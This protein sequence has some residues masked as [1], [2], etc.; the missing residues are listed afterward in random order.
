MNVDRC[1]GRKSERNMNS[2]QPV[3]SR[4]QA[5]DDRHIYKLQT[6]SC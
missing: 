1:A 2:I 5:D 4:M 3:S 6:F